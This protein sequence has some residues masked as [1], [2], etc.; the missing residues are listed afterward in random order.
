[1][2]GAEIRAFAVTQ[3]SFFPTQ[4]SFAVPDLA[5]RPGAEPAFQRDAELVSRQEAGPDEPQELP[6]AT[7][8]GVQ[9]QSAEV[10]WC[11]PGLQDVL[12]AW[13]G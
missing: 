13:G 11:A 3:A 9:P 4:V 10:D 8:S 5:S 2:F 6:G 1:M 12:P 7:R